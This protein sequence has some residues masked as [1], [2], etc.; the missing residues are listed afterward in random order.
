LDQKLG[1]EQAPD[2]V[3]RHLRNILI[4]NSLQFLFLES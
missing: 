2:P 1:L 3:F 4:L